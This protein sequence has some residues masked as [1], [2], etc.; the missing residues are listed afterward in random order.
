MVS[1][2][3][4][5]RSAAYD[6]NGDNCSLPSLETTMQTILTC[7]QNAHDS[8]LLAAAALVC[9]IGVAGSFLVAKHAA[10]AQGRRRTVL[11]SSGIVAAGC[12]AWA[13]HMIALLAFEPRMA[14]G[15]EPIRT[16]LSLLFAMLG[17]ATGM[18]LTVGQHRRSRRFLGGL[19]LG[20]GIVALHYV[21]QAAY[22][23]R[24]TVDYDL[25]LVALSV[26]I[27][28]PLFGLAL[29][30]A[31]EKNRR[32][33]YL[34][35]PLLLCAIAVLKLTGMASL[36]FTFDPSVTLP[37]WTLPPKLLAPIVAVVSG[38]LFIVAVAGLWFDLHAQATLRRERRRL[39]ELA[40][41]GLEGLAICDGSCIVAVNESLERLSGRS[42][43]SLLGLSVTELVPSVVLTELREREEADAILIGANGRDVPVRIIRSVVRLGRRLQTVVA[44]R[45]QRERLRSEEKIRAL[46][47]SDHLTGLANRMRFL[48]QLTESIGASDADGARFAVLLIDLDGFKTVNDALGHHGGDEVLRTVADRLRSVTPTDHLVAR[49]GGDEF[50]ILVRDCADPMRTQTL[51]SRVIAALEEPFSVSGQIVHISASIGSVLSTDH[52]LGA[53]QVLENADLALYDAKSK[54]RGRVRLFTHDLRQ[55]AVE[56]SG[57]MSDLQEAWEDRN[58]ELYYQPQIR[59]SDRAVVGAE[60]LIRWN[61]P[62]AG[63]LS[64]AAFLSV[65]ESSA[66]AVPV[67]T[68]ILET[69]C[70]Q[71]RAWREMGLADLRVGV[72]LFPAQLRAPDFVEVV[73]TILRETGLPPRALEI[74]VTENIVLQNE[75]MTLAH[76]ANLRR[77][78][79]KI[80]FDDFGT[81]FASLTMLKRIE[82][83]RLKVDRSFVQN[84]DTDERDQAIVDAIARMAKGCSLSVIAEGIET[85]EQALFMQRHAQEGQGY[86]FGRP[87]PASAFSERFLEPL[88]S[89]SAA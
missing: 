16:A 10:R 44:F 51:G 41:L 62:Y 2:C 54:G 82:L 24:G 63:V 28:L 27:S 23:V 43:Q 71:A 60:A 74:E 39:A 25:A 52:R 8:R 65:L 22:L 45:D 83:D 85:E 47:L 30:T 66:L 13:T 6:F 21:G 78:G 81:G 14:T 1:Y 11:A 50:A 31:G 67:G 26:A 86:L 17:I 56:R 61:R 38:G 64:P 36:Q 58:F 77:I 55:V 87:M 12:T 40:N 42:R 57:L 18:T 9:T 32:L 4:C 15:F 79:V 80:A 59:L 34:G 76:L 88:T 72:N 33:R 7:I 89:A 35:A 70:R 53:A 73:D 19:V 49:F 3:E 68:W 29:S 48:E 46:A 37:P 69:A 5:G 75:S 20:L 84:V